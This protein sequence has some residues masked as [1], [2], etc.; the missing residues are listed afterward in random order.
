MTI[1]GCKVALLVN[2][3]PITNLFYS[4]TGTWSEIAERTKIVLDE[5][6]INR[7]AVGMGDGGGGHGYAGTLRYFFGLCG[8]KVP[9][10]CALPRGCL[11]KQ[12]K[13][14]VVIYNWG[15]RF[16]RALRGMIVCDAPGGWVSTNAAAGWLRNLTLPHL[17]N[18]TSNNS[19]GS[20]VD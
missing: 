15:S 16:D 3:D 18:T 19:A 20:L 1:A 13:L 9:G 10:A 14:T 8:E 6:M 2:P 12:M 11:R 7:R 17:L 4:D 5:C